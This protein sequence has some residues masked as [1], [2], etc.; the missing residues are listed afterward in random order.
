VGDRT[1][2]TFL[3]SLAG[4]ALACALTAAVPSSASA[5][6]PQPVWSS[7]IAVPGLTALD[8]GNVLFGAFVSCTSDEDC[9]AAGDYEDGGGAN[10][11][12][13]DDEVD[14][15]WGQAMSLPRLDM[16]NTSGSASVNG[17]SCASDGNCAIGGYFENGLGTQA[18][19]DTEKNGSWQNAVEVPGVTS[20]GETSDV[21]A[22]SCASAGNCALT[23]WA[24]AEGM[25]DDEVDG[26][27]KLAISPTGLGGGEAISCSSPGNCGLLGIYSPSSG[28]FVSTVDDEVDGNWGSAIVVPD[29]ATVTGGENSGVDSAAISCPV[30]GYCTATS[31]YVAGG[32][33]F[34]PFVV[35]EVNG[36][37]ESA[38]NLPGVPTTSTSI[39]ID[40]TSPNNC[41]LNGGT[42]YGH[43][44]AITDEEVDGVWGQYEV[45]GG[46]TVNDGGGISCVSR[47]NC[48]SADGDV[49]GVEVRGTWTTAANDTTMDDVSCAFSVC[50]TI[51]SVGGGLD[52]Q[53]LEF[54]PNPPILV[55][56]ASGDHSIGVTWK[57]TSGAGST[58]VGYTA[59]AL[60]GTSAHDCSGGAT[61]TG[62]TI[63][64][65]TNG[66][67]YVVTVEANNA[68]GDSEPS[69][70]LAATPLSVP[71]PPT[72]ASASPR[73]RSIDVA[74][75]PPSDDGGSAISGYAATI[76]SG[77]V[78][79]N[80]LTPGLHCLFKE[81]PSSG[82]W[83]IGVVAINVEGAGPTAVLANPVYAVGESSFGVVAARVVQ[84][85]SYFTILAF[86]ADAGSQVT[87]GIPGSMHECSA[88][89]MGQCWI[90][91]R[92]SRSGIW[93]AVATDG[94]K[95]ATSTFY[96]PSV[97]IPEQV[98]HRSALIT[99][100][101]Y[102]PPKWLISELV[103]GKTY[104]TRTTNSGGATL[105]AKVGAVGVLDV[106]VTINGT[107][108]A[109]VSVDVT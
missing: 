75:S 19:L 45:L 69:N 99:S 42:G 109:A 61:A 65:L 67:E 6:T 18:F 35:A 83:T 96:A 53:S 12:W 108:F 15:T 44:E 10:Q 34:E 57:A 89:P 93:K 100:V 47:G 81:L 72:D 17:L 68:V 107:K 82:P 86:G 27:W 56:A 77:S 14:G 41:V 1:G 66:S 92:V 38:S 23:G 2:L 73:D 7:P 43:S 85:R 105:R 101:S 31:N 28:V 3:K 49:P 91:A 64:A 48:V 71:G 16:L 84:V 88:D 76:T 33:V 102:A 22:V 79:R 50:V 60:D 104:S 58:I 13:V 87:I 9:T 25:V 95:T 37:W 8:A 40:C 90:Q 5:S 21:R 39:S 54:A 51:G 59:T 29:I 74:W 70:A 26:I 32:E 98:V 30:N 106:I 62:C 97:R 52:V 11:V 103:S 94:S 80:C 78:R 46:E 24:G 4:F 63:F 20:L 36:T 55:A